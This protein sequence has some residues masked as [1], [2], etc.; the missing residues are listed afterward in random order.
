[1]PGRELGGNVE[2]PSMPDITKAQVLAILGFI[3]AQAVAFGW[4][5]PGQGQKYIAIGGIVLPAILKISDSYLRGQRANAFALQAY[6]DVDGVYKTVAPDL[7]AIV[8]AVKAELA[9]TATATVTPVTESPAP[10][11]GLTTG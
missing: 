11:A 4:L 9:T 5:N 6:R 10:A 7:P 2:K 1:M 3:A 8:A